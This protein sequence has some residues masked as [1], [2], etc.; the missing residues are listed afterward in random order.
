VHLWLIELDSPLERVQELMRT[1]SIDERQ[2]AARF[3]FRRHKHR[4]VLGRSSLRRLLARY[5]GAEAS[6]LRFRHGKHGKP[7]LERSQNSKS[8]D[9]NLAHSHGLAVLAITKGVPVGVDIEYHHRRLIERDL[10]GR[11]FSTSEVDALKALPP[12]DWQ[13]GFL[14]CW[15]RKE[16][17]LKARGEGLSF[18]LDAFT[19]SLT[20][21][22]PPRLLENQLETGE[23][24]LWSLYALALD[25]GYVG[26]LAIPE[27]RW[28]L[29]YFRLDP[30][31]A[32]DLRAS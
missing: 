30:S 19:V 12:G 13:Q 9:F 4:F 20:P 22:H 23:P 3:Q 7:A 18:P 10:A 6:A 32:H 11:F 15:V 24:G 31:D 29:R 25:D 2:R 8:L 5:L 27:N 28:R 1:L 16:A 17:Y 26:A 21:G 14:N